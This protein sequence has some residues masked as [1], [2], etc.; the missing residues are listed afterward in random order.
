MSRAF[1]DIFYLFLRPGH[2]EPHIRGAIPSPHQDEREGEGL[3]RIIHRV[4]MR[5]RVRVSLRVRVRVEARMW[6]SEGNAKGKG[7]HKGK[8]KGKHKGK[9]KG[10]GEYHHRKCKHKQMSEG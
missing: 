8:V 1:L 3:N 4:R 2:L 9:H 5:A 6:V 10:N 7:K